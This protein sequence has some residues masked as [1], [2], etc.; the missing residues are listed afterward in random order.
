MYTNDDLEI[1]V[2]ELEKWEIYFE[3][4]NGNN[5]DKF[6]SQVK[7]ARA[8]VRMIAESLKRTGVIELTER[9]KIEAKPVI[10]G[11]LMNCCDRRHKRRSPPRRRRASS[12]SRRRRPRTPRCLALR[13]RP[14]PKATWR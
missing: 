11:V 2:K 10:S 3:N 5:P 6:R 8:K 12:R 4:Y 13:V 1:A 7:A 9:E 14:R